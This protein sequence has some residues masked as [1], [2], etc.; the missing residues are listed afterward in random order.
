M[1]NG[2]IR[3]CDYHWTTGE[4]PHVQHKCRLEKN[5]LPPHECGGQENKGHCNEVCFELAAD[6]GD[7]L[8]DEHFSHGG[9]A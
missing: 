2:P 7:D 9:A 5:H 6:D 1:S 4:E 8:N 3:F